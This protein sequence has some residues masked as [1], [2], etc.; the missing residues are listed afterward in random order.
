M[1]KIMEK[2]LEGAFIA[3][4]LF[5]CF[6]LIKLAWFLKTTNDEMEKDC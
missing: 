3:A 5:F 2:I 6:G 4:F 1:E